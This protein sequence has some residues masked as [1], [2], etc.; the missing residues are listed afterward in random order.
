MIARLCIAKTFILVFLVLCNVK[1]QTND[2]KSAI[3]IELKRDNFATITNS[4]HPSN[5][6][7]YRFFEHTPIVWGDVPLST[8]EA[9]LDTALISQ[10]VRQLENQKNVFVY[11]R[12]IP[13]VEG[14]FGQRWTYYM[15]PVKDGIDIALLVETTREGLPEYYGVQQCFR[16]SGETNSDWRK[17][18]ALTSAFS[19]YDLWNRQGAPRTS[20]TSV[21]RNG[22]WEQLPA[23]KKTIG[24]RTPMGIAVDDL[25][26]NRQ[27]ES[28][29]GPYEA[30]MQNA[31]D[32][33]L[34]IRSDQKD[35]WHCG[36]HW[37]NASHV[38][39]HHPADCLHAIVNIGNIPPYSKRL[40]R[41]KIYWMKGTKNDVAHHYAKDFQEDHIKYKLK[42]AS[43][44]FPISE[45]I[46]KN[47]SWIK[48][49]TRLA[50]IKNCDI[51]HFAEGAL[52]GY[53]KADFVSFDGYD[54]ELLWRETDSILA[55]AKELKIWVVLGS[56]HKLTGDHKPHNSLYVIN[57]EGR[58]VDRFDKRFCTSGDLNYY[59]PGD[60]FTMFEINDVKCGLLICYDLRFPEL[61]REYVKLDADII[62]HSFNNSRHGIDCIH[63]KIMP[64]TAQARA[65]TNRFYMSLTNSSAPFG[66]PCQFITPD[67][68]I[69]GKLE[70][71]KPGILISDVDTSIDFYD[72]SLPYRMDAING[73][74]NSGE[75]VYDPKS[76]NRKGYK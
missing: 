34:I 75:I 40:I 51:V 12:E 43:C 46:T 32:N 18:I 2:I 58:I 38:T 5:R 13:N 7:G 39:N 72:A 71:N 44:Q 49:Q 42:V 56:A 29:V 54:W 48:E 68:L 63:P 10:K 17:E 59:S 41:G 76:M 35:T 70:A 62:F 47:S 64:I 6:I 66:W 21:L 52:S 15:T 1:A 3:Q 37:Q 4:E 45:D 74:L 73:K 11:R 25:R 19:E 65:G 67:G 36:I 55:L 20:L 28:E 8:R 23:A 16:L 26:T 14:W 50:K 27:P 60:H 61:F 30:H 31:I 22:V 53:A 9:N 69:N 24:T 33:G 57:P